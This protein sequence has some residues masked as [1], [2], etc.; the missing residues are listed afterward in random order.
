MELEPYHPFFL[1]SSLVR[2]QTRGS[3]RVQTTSLPKHK[4]HSHTLHPLVC[5]LAYL[6]TFLNPTPKS[7]MQVIISPRYLAGKS[8]SSSLACR[9]GSV[10]LSLYTTTSGSRD[11][12]NFTGE[13]AGEQKSQVNS[14]LG[15]KSRLSGSRAW[16][17][18][19]TLQ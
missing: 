19:H 1:T 12:P 10:C 4:V 11:Y 9:G 17:L 6:L 3:A 13:E 8:C 5:L 18:I 16:P 7:F 2:T 15:F 14:D